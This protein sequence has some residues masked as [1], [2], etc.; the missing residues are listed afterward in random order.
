[1]VT[2][3]SIEQS[4][5]QSIEQSIG[6]PVEQVVDH[7]AEALQRFRGDVRM[8]EQVLATMIERGAPRSAVHLEMMLDEYLSS[9]SLRKARAIMDQLAGLGLTIDP[10]RQYEVAIATA[11]A[12]DAAE[13]MGIIDRLTE[14]QRDPAPAQSATILDLLLAGGR[15]P[16]AWSLFRRMRA[17]AQQPSREAH[18]T[19][20]GD[21]L[22]RRA[23]K[24]TVATVQSMRAAGQTVPDGRSGPLLRMLVGLGQ[25]DR[26]LE[27]LGLLEESV[28]EGRSKRPSDDAY[29]ALLQALADKGRV[30]DVVTLAERL[31]AAGAALSSHHRNAVLAARIAASDLEGAWADAESMWADASL[32]T[33]ANLEGLLDMTLAAGNVARAAGVLDLLLV[34]GV[35]VTSQRSGAVIRAEMAADGLDRALPV[36]ATLLDQ[37]CVFDRSAAR[38]LVER[39]VRARRLDEARAWLVRFRTSGTLTQGRSYGSLLGALVAAKR[40]EEAIGLLEEMVSHKVRPEQADLARLVSGRVK[41]GDVEAAERMLTVAS[42]AGVHADEATLRELMWTFARGSD[43]AGVERMVVL[44]TSAGIA[45]DERHEKA[46]AWASGETARRLEDGPADTSS[47]ETIAGAAL[48]AAAAVAAPEPI[49]VPAPAP[50]LTEPVEPPS[51]ERG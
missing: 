29:G 23:A 17:R 41:A 49:D 51:D 26:A 3:Q 45:P 21:C 35:P 12:G 16:T 9:R 27:V 28:A 50:A 4:I 8:M 48:G 40:V 39:L 2:E 25:L 34:I 43:A 20:L 44:L 18:L 14:E 10:A 33:G 30:D 13:A 42:S 47:A 38:D 22:K 32:P 6:H 24:D 46:R 19:L 5:G 37:G 1:M 15:I 7:Y 31:G 36:A 11:T